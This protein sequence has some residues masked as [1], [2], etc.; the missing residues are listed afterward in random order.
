MYCKHEN[1]ARDAGRR[2]H[3]L[4]GLSE[5]DGLRLGSNIRNNTDTG[6]EDIRV[7]Y[8]NRSVMVKHLT[9]PIYRLTRELRDELQKAQASDSTN[10]WC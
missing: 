5:H 4:I 9:R 2:N 1:G 3:R 10:P 6:N 7:R 8:K